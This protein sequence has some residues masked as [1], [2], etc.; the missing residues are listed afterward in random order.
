MKKISTKPTMLVEDVFDDCVSSFNESTV[1]IHYNSIRANALTASVNLDGTFA[2]KTA[3]TILPHNTIGPIPVTKDDMIKLYNEK[4]VKSAK[5]RSYYN[6]LRLLADNDVCPNC[7]V[8]KVRT[9]DHFMAKSKYPIYAVTPINLY[10]C[11]SDCNTDKKSLVYTSYS[12][13]PINPYYDDYDNDEWLSASFNIIESLPIFNFYVNT[14]A[15]WA[16]ID[17]IKINNHCKVFKLFELFAKE[18]TSEF[19][20]IKGYITCL[21]I[22]GDQ[23]GLK[24]YF[25]QMY[26]GN[27]SVDLNSYK[28]AMY[29]CLMINYAAIYNVL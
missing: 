9:L 21:K 12:D 28:T 3:H 19:I 27:K 5:G 14:P 10:P 2:S 24:Q 18:A 4:L 7:G 15:T 25:D 16:A 29:K 23:N 1:R 6:K 20:S 17:T 13:T 8:R 22:V 26:K 11:C